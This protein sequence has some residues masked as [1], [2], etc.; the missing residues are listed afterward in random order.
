M[1][2]LVHGFA[3]AFQFA[4][5]IVGNGVGDH[6]ARF[7]QPDMALRRAFL[8]AG[9]AKQHGLLVA[10]GHRR[11][12]ADE[13]PQ[14]GHFG[15]DHGDDFEGIY[16]VVGIGAGVLGLHHQNAQHFAKPLDR[17][18]EKG[19]IGLFPGFGHVAEAARAGG[20]IGVDDL[21]GAGHAAHEALAQFHAGFVDRAGIQALG[22]AEFQRVLVTKQVDRAHLGAHFLGDQC[23][24]SVQPLLAGGVFGHDGAKAAQHLA[25]VGLEVL[26]HCNVPSPGRCGVSG[27]LFVPAKGAVFRPLCPIRRHHA[28]PE[29]QVPCISGRSGRKF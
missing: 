9:A 17:H 25:A 7:V 6:D 20:V 13:G 19:R 23:R 29:P 2:K 5:R 3:Q 15:D 12:F 16:L 22:G 1:R 21:A 28:V 4:M 8:P 11:A 24:D 26:R 18:P 10:C 27:P 14:F